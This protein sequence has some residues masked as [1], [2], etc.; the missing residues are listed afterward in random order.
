MRIIRISEMGHS[1]SWLEFLNHPRST[2]YCSIS[3]HIGRICHG[4]NQILISFPYGNHYDD[5]DE[6]LLYSDS[7]DSQLIVI[8]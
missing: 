7:V 4:R 1:F 3:A 6:L 8:S 5:C 2:K